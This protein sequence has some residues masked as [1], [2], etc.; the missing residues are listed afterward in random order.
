MITEL[1]K[2]EKEYIEFG[3]NRIKEIKKEKADSLHDK[4]M[5]L[6]TKH[7]KEHLKEIEK[8]EAQLENDLAN[9]NKNA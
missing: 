1:E 3:K 5:K 4:M 8:A 6:E 7:K 9:L 2:H